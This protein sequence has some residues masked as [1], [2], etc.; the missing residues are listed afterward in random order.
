MQLKTAG[1][2]LIIAITSFSTLAEEMIQKN[3]G[4][5]FDN[6]NGVLIRKFITPSSMLSA[7][8]ALSNTD[9]L[10]Q[11]SFPS[12]YTTTGIIGARHYFTHDKLSTFINLKLA[13]SYS[14][15]NVQGQ[16]ESKSINTTAL[17]T[18]GFEYF[19]STNVSIEAAAGVSRIWVGNPNSVDSHFAINT[20]FP[21][22]SLALTYYW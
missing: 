2:G 12:S 19:M 13:R 18:Y 17:L 10:D 11:N 21:A 6:T 4:I 15:I 8:I 7:G 22:T 3:Y 5:S 9:Y 14:R 20:I 16:E 1:L